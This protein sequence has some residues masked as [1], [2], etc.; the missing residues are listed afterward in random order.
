MQD[1]QD[2]LKV[3]CPLLPWTI[4]EY[5]PTFKT[6]E[7]LIHLLDG[8][9]KVEK[10]DNSSYLFTVRKKSI[11]VL[12]LDLNQYDENRAINLITKLPDFKLKGIVNVTNYLGDTKQMDVGEVEISTDPIFVWQ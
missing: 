6:Y 2:P 3:T 7:T 12:W 9:T 8:F 10:I 1:V 4:W 11:Y 5:R